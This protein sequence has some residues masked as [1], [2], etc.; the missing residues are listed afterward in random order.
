MNP[1]DP[2]GIAVAKTVFVK[3]VLGVV[4]SLSGVGATKIKQWN[5]ENKAK[6]LFVKIDKVRKVKTLW[7][8]D[9]A[10]DIKS[11]FCEPHILYHGNRYRIDSVADL[12]VF[13]R[14][15]L[16]EGAAGQGKSI[17]LRH[18]CAKELE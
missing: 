8:V 3:L 2:V 16:I 6:K 18:L 11:F 10:V 17:F 4:K 13:S 15:L 1:P 14:N 12:L 5:T 9:K 7:Q